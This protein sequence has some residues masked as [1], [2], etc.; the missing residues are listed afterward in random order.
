[1]QWQSNSIAVVPCFNESATIGGLV[2]SIRSHL[3]E[4]IVIDDGSRDATAE[5]ARRAGARVIRHPDNL[6][7]GAALRTGLAAAL[8]AGWSW[9]VLLD[10]D[11]QHRPEDIPNLFNRARIMNADLVIGNRMHAA[12]AMTW[13]R[14][15]T[16]RWMSRQLS[17]LTDSAMPDTQCGFRLLRLEAWRSLR[18]SSSRFEVDSEMVLLFAHYGYRVEFEPIPVIRSQ[19]RSHIRPLTDAWRW[20]RWRRQAFA[21]LPAETVPAVEDRP[22]GAA[23]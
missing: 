12:S 14:W 13:L 11:G 16:N 7:K 18:H 1:V 23:T 21:R 2:R 19:R 6:G 10:G 22:L 20:F 15:L 17:R 4:V 8:N 5:E 9:A 3:S